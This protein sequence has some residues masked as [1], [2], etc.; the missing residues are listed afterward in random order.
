MQLMY[1]LLNALERTMGNFEKIVAASGFKIDRV[2]PT[3]GT[4]SSKAYDSVCYSEAVTDMLAVIE[5][6]PV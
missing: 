5:L 1:N 3:R 2:Y 4:L 6:V